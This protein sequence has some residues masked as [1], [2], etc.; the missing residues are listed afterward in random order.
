MNKW[1]AANPTDPAEQIAVRSLRAR[2]YAVRRYLRRAARATGA[3]EDIHQLRV[4]ARRSEAALVVFADLLPRRRA[5]RLRSTIRQVRRAAGRIRDVDVLSQRLIASD[6][7]WSARLKKERERDVAKLIAVRRQLGGRLKR[8]MK[9]LITKLAVSTHERLF[10]HF[11]RATL[12]PIAA[13]FFDSSPTESSDEAALHRF[14][15]A[16]KEL[17]YAMELLAGAFPRAFRDELYPMLG[18]MQEK[19]GQINDLATFRDKLDR[20]IKRSGDPAELSD[21]RRLLVQAGEGLVL[22][23]TEFED[24]WSE[25]TRRDFRTRF[26]RFLGDSPVT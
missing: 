24:Q 15:I 20:R 16:S 21:L 13:A 11:A 1:T 6:C 25:E 9:K 22:A 14:R 12:Q 18:V 17:R 7:T 10:G 3:S 2:F 5:K 23:R 26:V 4:W 19:L 8:K